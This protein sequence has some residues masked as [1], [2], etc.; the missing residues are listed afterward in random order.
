MV[1]AELLVVLVE[2]VQ[3]RELVQPQ[4]RR[5]KVEQVGKVLVHSPT[6]LAAAAVEQDIMVVVVE[7]EVMTMD[8]ELV[9]HLVV[10]VDLDT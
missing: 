9:L 6:G 2:Q 8:Q 4:D 5:Y 10:G 7:A 1:L 3:V